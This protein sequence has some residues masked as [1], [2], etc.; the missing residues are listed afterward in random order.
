VEARYE[1][2]MRELIE[3][4]K[5]EGIRITGLTIGAEKKR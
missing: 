1:V 3:E 2:I 5:E 4:M